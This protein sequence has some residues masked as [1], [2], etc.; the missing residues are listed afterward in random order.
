MVD[1][2]IAGFW[3]RLLADFLD[4]LVLGVI[5]FAIAAVFRERLLA[6]GERAA[7]FGAP[8]TFV[9]TGVLQSQIGQGQT[10]A[11]RLLGLRVLR[12]DGRYLSLDRSLVRWGIMG[13]VVYGG[14]VA[15]ALS[16]IVP[17]FK[18]PALG[19]A[20][21]G[22]QFALIL[23]CALI[24]PFH[25]LK[26]GLHDLLTG[27]IVVRRGRFPVELVERLSNPVRDRRLLIAS[28]A[29]AIVATVGGLFATRHPPAVFQPEGRVM[30]SLS[31]M[32][33]QNPAVGDMF[34][35]GPGVD[36]HQIVVE[37]YVPTHA[38]GSGRIENA[39]ER[40]LALVRRE[41]PLAGVD[42]IVIN[43]RTGITIGVYSSYKTTTQIEPAIP[44]ETA[45]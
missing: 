21:A 28:L 27:S 3:I 15:S 12:L 10:L 1:A 4:A 39:D 44:G 7:L 16:T 41:M 42:R 26:R 24:V 23:G 19:A 9:Y 33:I 17:L 34:L 6:F 40:I 18:G 36:S 32:G 20:L 37:G 38:D 11:K 2:R 35:K 25:P 45:K 29:V 5:G 43:L 8:I 31:E 22:A 14:A 30:A 13:V